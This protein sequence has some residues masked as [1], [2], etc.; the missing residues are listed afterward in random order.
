MTPDPA[1]VQRQALEERTVQV[2]QQAIA[3]FP[4][5]MSYEALRPRMPPVLHGAPRILLESGMP[6]FMLQKPNYS[7][8]FLLADLKSLAKPGGASKHSPEVRQVVF[9][10][11]EKHPQ[12]LEHY[13][14][15]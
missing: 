9:E 5:G 11:L 10:S 12:L 8:E 13:L 14:R 1:V 6:Y 3:S 15:S 2:E 7:D 4:V